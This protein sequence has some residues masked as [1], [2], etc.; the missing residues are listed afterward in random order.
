MTRVATA[1]WL[2]LAR[3][4]ASLAPPHPQSLC[5][6]V[7]LMSQPGQEEGWELVSPEGG[8]VVEGGGGDAPEANSGAIGGE[9]AGEAGSASGPALDVF[10]LRVKTPAGGEVP[11]TMGVSDSGSTLRHA[12]ADVLEVCCE[13]AYELHAMSGEDESTVLNLYS[14]LGDYPTVRDGSVVRMVRVPYD[15]HTAA[16]HVRRLREVLANP[17]MQPSAVTVTPAGPPAPTPATGKSASPEGADG[18]AAA[19][20]APAAPATKESKAPAEAVKEA[21]KESAPAGE[22]A[23]AFVIPT[24]PMLPVPVPVSLTDLHTPPSVYKIGEDEPAPVVSGKGKAAVAP[25][26]PPASASD[27]PLPVAVGASVFLKGKDRRRA[28]LPVCLKSLTFSGFNPPPANR[29]LL[30][31][32]F[33][34]DAVTADN[35]SFTITATSAGFFINKSYREQFNP[36]AASASHHAYSLIALLSAASPK[37]RKSYAQVPPLPSFL[38][39]SDVFVCVCVGLRFVP[40]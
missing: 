31:D 28:P 11:L 9:A 22:D 40:M 25:V 23:K 37:F 12:L 21:A 10:C 5:V 20:P 8:G 7:Y 29:R 17:P 3:S 2:P 4:P 1:A 33:Y 34:I 35:A 39:L 38:S 14:P 26:G 36:A 30:G 32:L 15:T 27:A 16:A 24:L 6:Q 18:P 13:T 19:A